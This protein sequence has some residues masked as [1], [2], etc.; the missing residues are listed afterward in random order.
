MLVPQALL[1]YS[2][3]FSRGVRF[4]RSSGIREKLTGEIYDSY[5]HACSSTVLSMKH[6]TATIAIPR[7]QLPNSKGPLSFL[8]QPAAA[9]PLSLVYISLTS[10]SITII[11]HNL[12]KISVASLSS[13][14]Y[15]QLTSRSFGVDEIRFREKLTR[16]IFRKCYPPPPRQIILPRFVKKFTPKTNYFPSMV[17][18]LCMQPT[19]LRLH[20][21]YCRR[22]THMQ[23]CN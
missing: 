21:Q 8:V 20:P 14:N 4:S 10:A 1:P 3:Y 15:S 7:R 17:P 11:L 9:S 5:P 2:G 16:E 18:S 22:Y 23:Y 13:I 19:F 12:T 6:A